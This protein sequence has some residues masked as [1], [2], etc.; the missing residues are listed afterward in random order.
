MRMPTYEYDHD[1]GTLMKR[2]VRRHHTPVVAIARDLETNRN[3]VY[4]LLNPADPTYARHRPND[5]LKRRAAAFLG[6]SIQTFVQDLV[7]NGAN[8]AAAR[9]ASRMEGRA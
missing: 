5:E 7:N 8:L 4:Y 3:A 1:G 9:K 2:Y 6:V